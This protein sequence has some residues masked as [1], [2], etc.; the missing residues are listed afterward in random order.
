MAKKVVLKDNNGNRCYPVTRDECI[1]SGD[2]TLPETILEMNNILGVVEGKTFDRMASNQATTS[3]EFLNGEEYIKIQRGVGGSILFYINHPKTNKLFTKFLIYSDFQSNILVQL[4]DFVLKSYIINRNVTLKQGYNIIPLESTDLV[5]GNETI[6][7]IGKGTE[8]STFYIATKNILYYDLYKPFQ[9][10][11]RSFES[12]VTDVEVV[13]NNY[14]LNI[15]EAKVLSNIGVYKDGEIINEHEGFNSGLIPVSEINLGI[16]LDY[17]AQTLYDVVSFFD[18]ESTFISSINKGGGSIQSLVLFK[19][20]FP[21]NTKFIAISS[22]LGSGGNFYRTLG[23]TNLPG[24]IEENTNHIS[25]IDNRII[26]VTGILFWMS[27]IEYAGFGSQYD[28]LTMK[29]IYVEPGI[30]IL[31][32][33]NFISPEGQQSQ[34][35]ARAFFKEGGNKSL[36]F[37]S[38]SEPEKKVIVTEDIDYIE[39][40]FYA[41][42]NFNSQNGFIYTVENVSFEKENSILQIIKDVEKITEVSETV[43]AIDAEFSDTQIL[44]VDKEN[45]TVT[46]TTTFGEISLDGLEKR[47]PCGDKCTN[48]P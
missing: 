10:T 12:L 35:H 9:I 25:E 30:Y 34:F 28:Y 1:L 44:V 11:N 6:I 40:R 17:A 7:Y 22:I 16:T 32:A 45:Y 23:T 13:S 14:L 31:K 15:G 39:L 5:I 48:K 43:D 4:Y 38:N 41:S 21:I 18:N 20:D 46:T 29:K 33:N 2:K 19:R 8:S 27:K 26:E 47:T 3:S 42:L 24:K 36:G 37:C